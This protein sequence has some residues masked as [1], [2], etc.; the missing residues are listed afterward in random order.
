MQL[1]YL[2]DDISVLQKQHREKVLCFPWV[3]KL[4]LITHYEC[5]LSVA[6]YNAIKREL[7]KQI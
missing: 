4:E 7:Q 3:G 5:L 2:T 1:I 6:D